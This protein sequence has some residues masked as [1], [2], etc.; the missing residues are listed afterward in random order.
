[1]RRL[2][3]DIGGTR[4]K[5][6]LV[7]GDEIVETRVVETGSEQGPQAVIAR[8]AALVDE[9]G[10]REPVGVSLPGVF[11][12]ESGAALLLANLPGWE[13]ID[14]RRELS[15]AIGAPVALVNDGHAFAL[16]ESRLGAGRDARDVLCVVCGTGVGGA[17][18]LGGKLHRGVGGRAGEIGHTTVAPDGPLCGCGN[19]GCLELYAGSRAIAR[20]ADRESFEDTARAAAEG[21]TIAREA[22]RDA[23]RHIGVAV[24]GIAVVLEPERI[25]VGGGTVE[26]AGELLLDAARA[27]TRARTAG[28]S[29]GAEARVVG[30]RLGSFA[31]AIGAALVGA[32]GV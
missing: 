21:D 30:A 6:A 24:A 16:A 10:D 23:G 7:D 29:P 5:L 1:V 4:I 9:V 17:V 3:V 31:G 20:A 13:G 18:V 15:R 26:A 12:P 19:R 27:E 28:V 8:V 2:G 25:V 22:I 11:E 32:E 14:A